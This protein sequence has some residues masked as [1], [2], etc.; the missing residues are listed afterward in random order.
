MEAGVLGDG[1]E[2]P[3]PVRGKVIPDAV[4][5][6]ADGVLVGEGRVV[7][8]S[9]PVH[10]RSVR[11]H[12]LETPVA[13]TVRGETGPVTETVETDHVDG[14]AVGGGGRGPEHAA[15]AHADTP[16]AGEPGRTSVEDREDGPGPEAIAHRPPPPEGVPVVAP[17][18]LGRL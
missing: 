9:A 10:R 18:G 16:P 5:T 6:A 14:G 8:H 4:G 17:T 11:A 7:T 15:R 12:S 2:P 13:P 3:L 1:P